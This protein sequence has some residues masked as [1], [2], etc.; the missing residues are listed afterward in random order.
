VLQVESEL[1]QA[2]LPEA[3]LAQVSRPQELQERVPP[4]PLYSPEVQQL[5]EPQA[6]ER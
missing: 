5:Q 6:Q 3:H 2:R 1:E 4:E